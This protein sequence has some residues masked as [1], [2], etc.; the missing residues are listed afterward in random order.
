MAWRYYEAMKVGINAARAYLNPSTDSAKFAARTQQYDVLWAYYQNSVFE[1]VAGSDVW[2]KYRSDY[3]LYPFIR[4]IYN[5]VGRLVDF[6]AGAVYPGVL[7]PDG[8]AL[9]DGVPLAIP[10]SKDTPDDL[11]EAIAQ[12][13]A[14]SNWQA[15]SRGMV[16]Y[17]GALGSVLV[18]VMDEVDRGKVTFAVRW[19]GFVPD[20]I[21]DSSGNVKFYAIEFQAVDERGEVYTFRK[22]VSQETIK[23]FRNG[24]PWDRYGEG[25]VM[26]NPYGF[27]PAVWIK[28]MDLGGDHGAPA[29]RSSLGK[30]D[31]LNDL[32]SRIHHQIARVIES[33]Q[34][35]W[36]NSP[37][38]N[39]LTP[40]AQASLSEQ[41]KQITL[42]KGMQG[43]STSTLA[44][45]LDLA[46][47]LP[48]LKELMS[49]ISADHPELG[50]FEALRGMSSLTGP[51]VSRMLGDVQTLVSCAAGNYDNGSIKLFQM[52]TA[53][54]GWRA[55]SGAWGTLSRAQQ[56]FKPF[57]LDS[58][59]R[60]LLDL[61][62]DPRP[63]VPMITTEKYDA[64]MKRATALS[65]YTGAGLSVE[66][67][68]AQLG[69]DEQVI[70]KVKV[71][72]AADEAK[73]AAQMAAAPQPNPMQREPAR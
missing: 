38:S 46:A 8:S 53:I 13:W 34:L 29:I 44:G 60:G 66:E 36:T 24:T 10:L 9:P 51:A 2:S 26:P 56:K 37:I 31:A 15:G 49:E 45:N 65:T 69:W 43:G 50:T 70:A 7:S 47:A 17:G 33:P 21:L 22:E 57:S 67:G 72:R 18:E 63:I 73:M 55:S 20:L 3:V 61:S 52:G 11:R 41:E 59:Q 14:W 6:Y 19:P 71:R 16:T 39:A 25:E 12:L 68:M 62:I 42:L 5:P 40:D 48:Y 1:R 58:Y 32:A 28:H 23:Y 27:V 35:L 4:S 30:V 64:E 54:S